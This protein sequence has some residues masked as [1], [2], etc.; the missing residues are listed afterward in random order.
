[1]K[2]IIIPLVIGAQ[3]SAAT[4]QPASANEFKSDSVAR[5]MLIEDAVDGRLGIG[6]VEKAYPYAKNGGDLER[7][8]WLALM[9]DPTLLEYYMG[10]G[11]GKKVNV[12]YPKGVLGTAMDIA[13]AIMFFG[14]IG[15][16]SW[17]DYNSR[18]TK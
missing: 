9:K 8:M 10:Q 14:V 13:T 15:F 1:M 7:A 18:I 6:T 16:Y 5:R 12:V 11:M 17:I 4:P 3:I 2:K